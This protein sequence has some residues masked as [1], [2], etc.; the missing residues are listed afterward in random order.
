MGSVVAPNI[1]ARSIALRPTAVTAPSSGPNAL[2][3]TAPGSDLS[4]YHFRGVSPMATPS[5]SPNR[6]GL[7]IRPAT[8]AACSITPL[9]VSIP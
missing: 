3:A 1:S 9:V 5:S 7:T 6:G 4:K 8:A 2:S